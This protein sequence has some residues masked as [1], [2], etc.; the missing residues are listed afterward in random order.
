M[1]YIPY[2][3]D[4]AVK[5]KCKRLRHSDKTAKAYLYWIHRFLNW[6]KRDLGKISKKDV[7]AFLQKLDNQN[8]SGNTLNQCHMALKFLFEDV[9]DKKMWIN[10]KYTK[11]PKRIQRYL[12]KEEIKKLIKSIKNPKHKL[13]VAL[14]YSAGLR[15]SEVINLKIKEINFKEGYGFVRNGKGNK[16]RV[17]VL[18]NKLR[19]ALFNLCLGKPSEEFVFLSNRG[20]RY[21]IK[22]F[23]KIIKNAAKNAQLEN[24]K[25][26]HPHTLR[27]SF[28]THLLE[29]K[30]SI[31]D[32]QASLGH[33]SPETSLVYTH[34]NGKMINI[35][36]PLDSL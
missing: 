24:W 15:V 14:M 6:S 27:H 30:Y 16:D 9:M 4:L 11:I 1:V 7:S 29:N 35:K 36:S 17:F 28:A 22:S 34:T 32:V 19:V 23:Q 25:E 12:T 21:S 20:R 3:V 26:I 18:S 10:I 13:I 2:D 33:K 8:K 31:S 5:R